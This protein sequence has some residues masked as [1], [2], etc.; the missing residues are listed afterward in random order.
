[1]NFGFNP[2]LGFTVSAPETDIGAD[3][4]PLPERLRVE[5]ERLHFTQEQFAL[6]GGISKATQWHYEAG[7]GW[8]TME[9]LQ[10]LRVNKVD[11]VYLVSG[12][13]TLKDR[14]DWAILREAFFFILRSLVNRPNRHFTENQLFDAFRTTVEAAMSL[15]RSAS[16]DVAPEDAEPSV[17]DAHHDR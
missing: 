9:Y 3:G 6:L 14:L 2:L 12:Q 7:R 16:G 1:M 13:R 5:R 4:L 11:V 17:G 10:R 8:P 15:T